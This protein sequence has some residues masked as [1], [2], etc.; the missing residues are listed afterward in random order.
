MSYRRS[1]HCLLIAA[2]LLAGVGYSYAESE[3]ELLDRKI[4]Q[5]PNNA[6]LYLQRGTA[7][8]NEGDLEEARQDFAKAAKLGD[9]ANSDQ[10]FG[11]YY[12]DKGDFKTAREY[13]DRHLAKH[14]D[15]V[16]PLEKRAQIL[17]AQNELKKSVADYR[18]LVQLKTQPDPSDFISIAEMVENIEGEGM[19]AALNALDE[20]LV[21]LRQAPQIQLK[22][23]ELEVKQ[24]HYQQAIQRQIS[25]GVK[26]EHS[27]LWQA[28]LADLYF[29][30]GNVSE[31]AENYRKALD[32]LQ[33][34][35]SNPA[36]EE[37]KTRVQEALATLDKNQQRYR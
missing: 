13:F 4:E 37:L 2:S 29:L 1:V 33:K 16:Y 21:R 19:V 12:F 22:A 27:P 3:T 20:G 23:I 34:F 30:N 6:S 15:D 7:S 9:P 35:R 14:P 26:L 11:Y 25:L 32:S 5:Q 10:Y 31:A 28:G 36:R 24:H 8:L 17:R 18:K